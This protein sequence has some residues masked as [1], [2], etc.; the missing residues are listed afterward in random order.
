MFDFF[1]EV[2]INSN[3]LPMEE[4]VDANGKQ[5]KRFSALNAGAANAALRV[6]RC[7]DYKVENISN[8]EVYYTAGRVGAV[9]SVEM[10][11]AGLAAGQYRILVDLG[12]ENRYYSDYAQPWSEFHKNVMVEFE[13]ADGVVAAEAAM[14]ALKLAIPADYKFA[15]AVMNGDVVKLVCSDPYQVIK[16]AKLQMV[17]ADACLD[18]CSNVQYATVKE[19]APVK[20]VAP[21]A[22]GEWLVENLR[23]PTY[24]NLRYAAVNA[25]EMPIA[26]AMYHQYT[27]GYCI[28]RRG[29]TG[30]GAVGQMLSSVTHHVFYVLDAYKA[31]FDAVLEELGLTIV[32]GN[33]S[34][35]EP[36]VAGSI[37]LYFNNDMVDTLRVAQ[38][39]VEGGSDIVVEANVVG[40][41]GTPVWSLDGQGAWQ[42]TPNADGK[43][44]QLDMPGATVGMKATLTVSVGKVSKTVSIEII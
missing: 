25:D 16:C 1:K 37:E 22:T 15:V 6:L 17:E 5:F 33:E 8:K 4:G 41:E 39:T 30:Q 43:S 27:F 42:V 26:G 9:A 44:A 13:V 2:I 40:V 24:P 29:M 7:A 11:L 34:P 3:V 12:L 36:E 31:E 38:A 14:K 10:D 21:F 23:F 28:A 35:V 32:G 20:N 18:G 19:F